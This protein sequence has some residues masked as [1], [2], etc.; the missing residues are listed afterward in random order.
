MPN[1]S[2]DLGARVEKVKL[3][4]IRAIN[5]KEHPVNYIRTATD[6]DVA[7]KPA[8]NG[9][10]EWQQMSGALPTEQIKTIRA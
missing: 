7:C 10:N 6:D 5:A 9:F 4:A 2:F 1:A 8:F 3:P